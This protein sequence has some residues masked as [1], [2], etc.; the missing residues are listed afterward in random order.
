MN[1][2]KKK[3]KNMKNEIHRKGKK[4]KKYIYIFIIGEIHI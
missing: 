3:H 4:Q 2:Y 1:K